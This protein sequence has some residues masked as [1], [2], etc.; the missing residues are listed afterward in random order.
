[1]EHY[2]TSDRER[3]AFW[4]SQ[5]MSARQFMKPYIEAGM[6][7]A[8]MYNQLPANERQRIL[9]RVRRRNNNDER[10][11]ASLVFAWVDQSV[12]GMV[13][14]GE[15][16][17]TIKAKNRLG[18]DHAPGVRANA[19][20][21]YKE[22]EQV[23]EDEAMALD[24]HLF[25]FAVKKIGWEYELDENEEI[26]LVDLAELEFMSADDEGL[27]LAEGEPTRVTRMQD[28]DEHIRI[29][30][31]L[32]EDETIP[33][34]IKDLIIKPHIKRHEEFKQ[35][36]QPTPHANVKYSAPFGRRW[37]IDDFLMDPAAL[38]GQQ[39]A[40]WIA[41]RIR[42]PVYRWKANSN[43]N[44]INELKPNSGVA[45][46]DIQSF[47][48]HDAAQEAI[49]DEFDDYALCEGWEIWARDFPVAAG[50]RQNLL[51]VMIE[52]HDTLP[53]HEEWP[54]EYQALDDYPVE[55]LKFQ[56][57]FKSWINKPTLTL[58]GADNLQALQTEFLDA[59]LYAMRKQKSIYLA[60]AEVY[61]ANTLSNVTEMDDQSVV[62]VEGLAAAG[63]D[64]VQ[65][66]PQQTLM[67]DWNQISGI[68][69][70]LFD[71]SAGV[72]EPQRQKSADTATE[73]SIIERRV[74]ARE[75]RRFLR[76][77][78]MQ[79]NTARKW[80]Q[81][82]TQAQQPEG[83]DIIDP[84][85]NKAI[86]VTPE[87]AKGEYRFDIDANAR[88]NSQA[89]QEN[90]ALKKLNLFSG[91][92]PLLTQ[93]GIPFNLAKV[94]EDTLIAFGE[95]DVASYMPGTQDE[96]LQ[97]LQETLAD[98]AAKDKLMMLMGSM[99]PGG[100]GMGSGPGPAVPQEYAANPGTE[101]RQMAEAGRL[102]Q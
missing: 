28:Q 74:T 41:F 88:R 78:R 80:W 94:I 82:Q 36:I 93:M 102:E 20:Y 92:M 23:L 3:K 2:P 32:L 57:N 64:A 86:G 75:D 30:G 63:K 73:A 90:N 42:Q 16:D 1:M 39:D 34:E 66:W 37:P 70:Q 47:N 6:M 44:D 67:Q 68:Y 85:T 31:M 5:L 59:M 12:A 79:A 77:R 33:Q 76:F 100:N 38:C 72:P 51:C 29:N 56:D 7:L 95:R 14:E 15:V 69:M 13:S 48:Q 8:K 11:K 35:K 21:W 58:A 91:I 24:A 46:V 55:V 40:R 43:Y 89:V 98:P 97:A 53:Q 4:K 84:R 19:N 9:D 99:T 61:D 22:T 54:E 27:Y 25:S 101:S 18:V 60:D 10:V 62:R 65:V 52:T 45:G 26:K 96:F 49:E 81:L 71:K 83:V 50:S 17:F 87:M